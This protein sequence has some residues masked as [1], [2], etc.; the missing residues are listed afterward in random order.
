MTGE[1]AGN[2][3]NAETDVHAARSQLGGKLGYRILSLSH[4]HAIA[5]GDNNGA[6]SLEKLCHISAAKLA[7]LAL[8]LIV[9]SQRLVTKTAQDNRQEGTV[10]CLAHD[11]GK[12]GA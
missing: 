4:G 6:G 3:V 2:R 9:S 1:T 12:D 8:L 7:D 10:H 5:R 11:V